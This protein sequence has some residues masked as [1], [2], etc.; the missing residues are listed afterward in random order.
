MLK[1]PNELSI[2]HVEVLHQ[3]KKSN[4]ITTL[5]TLLEL[6]EIKGCLVTIDAMGCQKSIAEKIVSKEA[7]YLL[8]VKANHKGLLSQIE[9]ALI[10]EIIRKRLKGFCLMKQIIKKTERSLGVVQC[11][12]T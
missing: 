7:D 9:G 4:E 11:A 3:D 12:M 2:V 6:L 1:L 5:P 10:P 8:A